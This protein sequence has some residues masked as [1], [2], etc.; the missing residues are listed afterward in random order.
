VRGKVRNQL[1]RR[2]GAA[3][4]LAVGVLAAFWL[5]GAALR[6]ARSHVGTRL[7][8]FR[9]SAFVVN[10]PSPEAAASARE[11][12]SDA[13]KGAF[14]SGRCAEI[15]A[16]LR[17]RHPGLSSVR[18][19]RNFFTGKATITAKPEDVVSPVLLNGATAYL[20]VSGRL[21]PENLSA[22]A[23]AGL[24]VTIGWAASDAPGL[25]SFL[26]GL[27]PL[28]PLFYSRPASL[29]CPGPGWA[30]RLDL[31]D[32]SSV[33]WGEFEFT[34]LK[35]IRLNEVVKDASLKRPGPFR[36]DMRYFREGKILVSAA[37]QRPSG[38]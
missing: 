33:L 19:A 31:E 13:L 37:K 14:T 18:V 29:D 20:G 22:G 7:L 23:E 38:R 15:A 34:R 1:L 24:P 27:K 35:I 21:M 4:G 28:L 11:L 32:G 26:T 25:A 16:E 9:P 3:A 12:M 10:C 5:F 17:H 2:G 8:S 36:V 6:T 30:C